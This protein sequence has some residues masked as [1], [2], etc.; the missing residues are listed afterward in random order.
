MPIPRK[1]DPNMVS[2]KWNGVLVAVI[3]SAGL[4]WGQGS[5]AQPAEKK[6]LDVMSVQETGKSSQQCLILNSWREPDGSLAF[7]VQSLETR[8]RMTIV[9]MAPEN[10]AVGG[11][12]RS[13]IYRW[14]NSVTSPPG[15]PRSPMEQ[16]AQSASPSTP[17]DTAT[18]VPI[19]KS[20]E[21]LSPMSPEPSIEQK[22]QSG[23]MP[24]SNNSSENPGS[25][26][27]G[28][29]LGPVEMEKAKP[30]DWRRSWGKLDDPTSVVSGVPAK[31][32]DQPKGVAH[33]ERKDVALKACDIK[34]AGS[35]SASQSVPD[36]APKA[37]PGPAGYV[38]V[39]DIPPRSKLLP[40]SQGPG[41]GLFTRILKPAQ[42]EQPNTAGLSMVSGAAQPV[43]LA[44]VN[45]DS[46]RLQAALSQD[47]MPSHRERAAEILATMDWRHDSEIL[48]AI[49]K[50]AAEDPAATVRAGCVRCLLQMRADTSEAIHLLQVLQADTDSRVREEAEK[51]LAALGVQQIKHND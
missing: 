11:T 51:A 4:V 34:V 3:A 16:P 21:G 49:L 23:A 42:K 31:D 26:V 44:Q 1:G 45:D 22:V 14:G 6:A 41:K 39:T 9:E 24:G 19:I 2:A 33:G 17:A 50:A 43:G 36:S 46:V 7:E 29:K 20:V 37:D 15:V 13:R 18:P 25:S 32:Q 30:S 5:P 48:P 28:A 8:E 10:P 27:P 35:E 40:T 47:L 12:M 38:S